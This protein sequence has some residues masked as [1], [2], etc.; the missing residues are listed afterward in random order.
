MAILN[1]GMNNFLKKIL[2]LWL[3][4]YA[5]NKLLRDFIKSKK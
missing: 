4:F 5:F 2:W 3:P 1:E